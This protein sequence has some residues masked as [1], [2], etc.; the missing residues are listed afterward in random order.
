VVVL[1]G[2]AVI[3]WTAARSEPAEAR[4]TRRSERTK[5]YVRIGEERERRLATLI[6]A[7]VIV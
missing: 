7:A 5:L 3:V 6:G 4:V 1:I 2:A